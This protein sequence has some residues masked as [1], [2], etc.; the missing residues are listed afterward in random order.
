[1]FSA[2]PRSRSTLYYKPTSQM[3]FV[4][5]PRHNVGFYLVGYS[6]D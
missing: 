2:R 1:M 5:V 6:L 3:P 4:R